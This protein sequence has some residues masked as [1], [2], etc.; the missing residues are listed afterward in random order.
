[1]DLKID[2]ALI[3]ALFL[4][5]IWGFA[6]YSGAFNSMLLPGPVLVLHRLWELFATLEIL[7]DLLSTLSKIGMALAIGSVIGF[8]IGIMLSK[9]DWVYNLSSP[10]QDFFR[11]LPTTAMF[12][13]FLIIVGVGD[14]TNILLATWICTLYLS[15]HVS[16][17]LRATG[18]T[19]LSMAKSL[20]K[21]ELDILFNVKFREALPTIFLGFR[22][23][24]SLSM[25]V[26]IATEMFVGTRAGLG[27]ALI[28]S[29]YTYDTP[30]VYAVLIILGV[31]GHLLNYLVLK[32]E[33][34]VVHW[35]GK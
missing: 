29:A 9:W 28:D 20:K 21:T 25:V 31:T 34:R 12:P 10:L 5:S 22:T 24:T 32:I 7:A 16:E 11:S 15:L 14:L 13:L 30:K 26:M 6:S 27:K 8:S 3:S 19:Y 33:Q 17:G 35:Q 4:L 23:M 2:S 1:M 18:E